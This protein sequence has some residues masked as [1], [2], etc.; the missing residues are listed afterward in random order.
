MASEALPAPEIR[1]EILRPTPLPLS[2]SIKILTAVPVYNN[3]ETI[4]AVVEGALDLGGALLVV[5]DGSD[6]G[7]LDRVDGL[8]IERL[9]FETNRGKGVALRAAIDFAAERGFTHVVSLD[10]DGQHDPADLPRFFDAIAQ[11]PDA[12]IVGDR[13]MEAGGAP[14]SSIFGRKFSNFWYRIQTGRALADCQCGYRAYP[15]AHMRL[16]GL[17]GQRFEF[18]TEVLVKSTWAGLPV[19][20]IPIPV[21]YPPEDERVSHFDRFWDNARISWLNTKLCVRRLI[22]IP[23]R[24]LV[25]TPSLHQTMTALLL[26]P[27]R[28]IKSVFSENATPAGLALAA[29]V[30]VLIGATPIFGLHC[31]AIVYVA[32][33]LNLNKIMAL[34]T[35]NI[36]MPPIVPALCI[37]LGYFAR[38]GEFLVDVFSLGAVRQTFINE[39]HHRL[40]EWAIGS[41]IVGPSLGVSVAVVVYFAARAARRKDAV[42]HAR[43]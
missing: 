5:D 43:Q 6:D 36:C 40:L 14:P 27:V 34:A 15:A 3:A 12:L 35:S 13:D 25:K 37:E 32:T 30:G 28:S 23:H 18:E 31:V 39:A 10:A 11:Q 20:S 41:L 38:H 1:T 29:A 24:K 7:S 8:D 4:R 33:R 22:P 9:R 2:D 26:H 17:R 21:Y 16:L 19:V 42:E